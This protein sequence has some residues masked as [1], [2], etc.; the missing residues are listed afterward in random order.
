MVVLGADRLPS[1]APGRVGLAMGGRWR[2]RVLKQGGSPDRHDLGR[3]P[4][5]GPSPVVNIRTSGGS[6]DG[7]PQP[8]GFVF[9]GKPARRNG[10][11]FPQEWSAGDWVARE[12]LILVHLGAPADSG[13]PVGQ[14][15]PCR[16][17]GL[18]RASPALQNAPGS[19]GISCRCQNRLAHPS[20]FSSQRFDRLPLETLRSIRQDER[21]DLRAEPSWRIPQ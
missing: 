20:I 8:I 2:G 19:V 18:G 15:S 1:L 3:K 5:C 11:V 6:W 4:V 9:P 7:P 17:T 16:V 12:V 14:G 21:S 13:I 10:F